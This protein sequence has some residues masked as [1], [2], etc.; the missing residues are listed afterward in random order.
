MALIQPVLAGRLTSILSQP[1]DN[2]QAKAVEWASAYQTYAA[3]AMAGVLLPVFTGSEMALF[4]GQISPVFNNPNS[5]AVQFANALAS[6]VESFWFLPPVPFQL[7]PVA[8]AVTG[9]PGK[10]ALIAQL[11]SILGNQ[12]KQAAQPAQD[13]ATA[14]DTA[15]RTVIVTFA[16]PPG[17]TA[18][19]V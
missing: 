4:L 3:P 2:A 14:L 15:T 6:A 8:G 13:I 18:T 5:T 9:F 19:L 17:S 16:P 10:P 1:G 12:Y 7:L 11:V